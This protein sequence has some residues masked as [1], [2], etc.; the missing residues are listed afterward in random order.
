MGLFGKK[1]ANKEYKTIWKHLSGLPNYRNGDAVRVTMQPD[2]DTVHF[3]AA[4]YER[5]QINLPLAKIEDINVTVDNI[6]KQKDKSVIGRAVVGSAVAGPVGGVVGGLSGVGKKESSKLQCIV[7][8]KYSGGEEPIIFDTTNDAFTD[9]NKIVD[10]IR[11]SVRE[12]F[13]VPSE[14]TL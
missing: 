6:T 11:K 2:G 14:I 4:A 1:S 8:V 13:P 9:G 12:R 7:E 5:P 10:T 3:A